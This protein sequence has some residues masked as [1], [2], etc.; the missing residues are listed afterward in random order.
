ML[1]YPISRNQCLPRGLLSVGSVGFVTLL[2]AVW[3]ALLE[4]ALPHVAGQDQKK[5]NP[6]SPLSLFYISPFLKNVTSSYHLKSFPGR[7]FIFQ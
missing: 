3:N 5:K 4:A 2:A 7:P 1:S 6:M